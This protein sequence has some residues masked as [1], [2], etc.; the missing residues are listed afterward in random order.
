MIQKETEYEQERIEM[1]RMLN[2]ERKKS[3]EL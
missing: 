2:N 3:K 1:K